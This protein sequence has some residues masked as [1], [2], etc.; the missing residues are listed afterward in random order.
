MALLFMDGFGGAD[1]T[2]KWDISSTL[3][4]FGSA[5]PRTTGGYYGIFNNSSAVS[6]T[7]PAASQVFFGHG[8]LSTGGGNGGNYVTFYGDGGATAHITVW[9]NTTSGCLMILRGTT[10]GT[11]LTIGTTPIPDSTWCYIEVSVTISDTVGQ[12]HVRL[13]GSTTDEVSF[14]GDTKSG[15]TNTTIDRVVVGSGTFA[16]GG[17]NSRIS[18]VYILNSLGTTNNTFLGDVAVR[19]LSPSGNG[20]SSQLIGS[21][22]NSTDNYLLLDE[23]PPSTADYVGSATPGQKDTYAIQD[24]PAGVTTVYGYQVTGRMAKVDASLGQARYVLR[25][26]GTD[27]TGTT[28]ALS[29]AY[30][31]YSDLY[32]TDP[33][34]STA[35]TVS[36]VNNAELGMEIV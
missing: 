34:T 24:L 20:N 29:T 36:G 1:S 15:G 9:R 17:D 35:W 6:K 18:D 3:L 31:T 19:T 30:N 21:D 28:R 10:G 27:Y 25:S 12:V 14:T 8:M 5:S 7:F 23:H 4:A 33:A 2:S 26:A 13:N 16:G 22:G 32:E 11:F